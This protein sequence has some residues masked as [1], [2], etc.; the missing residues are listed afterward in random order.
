MDRLFRDHFTADL[1]VIGLSG[2]APA[3]EIS[4]ALDPS[5]AAAGVTIEGGAG[6]YIVPAGTASDA[7]RLHFVLDTIGSSRNWRVLPVTGLPKATMSAVDLSLSGELQVGSA[8]RRIRMMEAGSNLYVQAGM[9]GASA[10]NGHFF[11]NGFNGQDLLSYNVGA[12]QHVYYVGGAQR[13]YVHAGGIGLAGATLV[14][15]SLGYGG[16]GGVGGS[17][18]QAGGKSSA[19][20]LDKIC[21]RVTMDGAELAAGAAVSFALE[22]GRIAASDAIIVNIAGGA[23]DPSAYGVSVGRVAAGSCDIVVR[24]G[25]GGAL[26]EALILNFAVLK[27]V[28]A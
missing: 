14:D 15:G 8:T 1:T 26:S 13:L 11:F 27:A 25:S 2:G 18:T 7:V 9:V 22:N 24:N 28:A 5:D 21:G 17:V 16:A 20:T 10:P 19:V 23:A 6:P 3:G 4:V 12:Q